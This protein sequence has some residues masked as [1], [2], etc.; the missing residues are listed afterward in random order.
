MNEDDLYNFLN[1]FGPHF[2]MVDVGNAIGDEV[3]F[4]NGPRNS[5]LQAIS[6]IDLIYFS[7][8]IFWK[9]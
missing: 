8:N 4:N 5:S 9:V 7:K 1:A 6:D 2:S 3:L